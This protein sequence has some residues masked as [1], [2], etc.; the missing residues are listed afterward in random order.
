MNERMN[1]NWI[2]GVFLRQDFDLS[3][4]YDL[5][6]GLWFRFKN[7]ILA[8]I[9]CFSSSGRFSAIQLLE[10]RREQANR[11][12]DRNIQE[13]YVYKNPQCSFFFIN[14]LICVHSKTLF[15][16]EKDLFMWISSISKVTDSGKYKLQCLSDIQSSILFNDQSMLTSQ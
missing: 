12:A 11:K 4:D 5:R 14:Y 10:L 2:E 13:R 9:F 1:V 6:P 3:Q 8:D 15:P 16:L 7:L